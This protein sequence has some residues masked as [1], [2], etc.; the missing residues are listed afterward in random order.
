MKKKIEKAKPSQ[1]ILT[2]AFECLS[3]KGYANVSMRDIANEA[4]VALSHLT[5][6]YK[7]KEGLFTEVINMMMHQYLHEIEDSLKSAASTK[8]KI[9]SLVR[10][11]KEL[12]RDKP[13]LLRLFIDF[14]AQA[15]WLPSFGE[16]V[17]SLFNNLAEIIDKNILADTE[18][19]K[20]LQEYSSKSIARLILGALY[21]VSIQIMLGSDKE[22]TFESLNL[23][24]SLLN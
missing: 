16:Q 4:G 15:L 13:N 18:I 21:G 20:G 6:Y 10:Y 2:T 22:S 9:A 14:T 8:E 19:C 24:E 23:A 11:F 5:Y 12:I 3:T 7:N 1:K 17:D